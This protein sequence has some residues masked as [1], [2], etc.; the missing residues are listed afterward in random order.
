MQFIAHRGNLYGPNSDTENTI[1]VIEECIDKGFDI[2]IDIHYN[3]G[4]FWLGHDEPQREFQFTSLQL[5]N[6]QTTVYAHC[7]TV[8]ALQEMSNR[9][10]LASFRNVIPFFHDV[11][12]C[13]LLVSNRLW[14]HPRAVNK[15]RTHTNSIVVL[16]DMKDFE[17]YKYDDIKYAKAICTDYPVAL[18]KEFKHWN[19]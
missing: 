18:K 15:V 1:P 10:G 2:E 17:T 7:K 5:W 8:E 3:D 6:Y 12:D 13:I 19:D 4:K 9:V 14:I 16:P 11:D